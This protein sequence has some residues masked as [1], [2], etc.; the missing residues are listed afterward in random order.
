MNLVISRQ[1]LHLQVQDISLIVSSYD[2][3]IKNNTLAIVLI[4][5]YYFRIA[6]QRPKFIPCESF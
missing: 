1:I 6:I 3:F 2:I 5:F 4:S